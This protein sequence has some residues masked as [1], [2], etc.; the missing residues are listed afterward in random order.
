MN[1]YALIEPVILT[2]L[3]GYGLWM[4]LRKATPKLAMT[5]GEACRKA[6]IP[7]SIV[8]PVFGPPPNRSGACGTCCGCDKSSTSKTA[9][10]AFRKG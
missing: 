5:I 6:G 10:I 4:G 7:A 8:N 9:P 2:L 3:L 1:L